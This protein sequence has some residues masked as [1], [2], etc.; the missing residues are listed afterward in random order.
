MRW[1]LSIQR[2][3]TVS[4]FFDMSNAFPSTAWEA[5]DC[6]TL[7]DTADD[8][9]N[10][11]IQRYRKML[12]LIRDPDGECL[13]YRP[14]TGDRQGDPPAAPRYVLAVDPTIDA[15]TRATTSERDADRMRAYDDWSESWKI[16]CHVGYADDLARVGSVSC[17]SELAKTVKL[18]CT[19]L[20]VAT[21]ELRLG[22]NPG[23][24]EVLA[25]LCPN[26][27]EEY[28]QLKRCMK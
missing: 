13:L 27:K 21:Q 3:G 26:T 23:K 16:P 8:D 25:E 4:V 10:L 17:A 5:L 22:Q 1:R 28:Q 7:P 9:K 19:T 6:A 11:L 14:C 12:C 18:W 24:M 2:M 15:W 20:A